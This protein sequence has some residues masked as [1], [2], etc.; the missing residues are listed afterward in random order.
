[1]TPIRLGTRA[2]RLALI[3]SD[4]VI[5]ALR[6]ADPAVEVEIV[7]ITSAG[8]RDRTTPLTSGEGAGWFTSALQ[9]ALREGAVDFL[10]HSYKDLPTAR[11]EGFVIAAV[12]PRADPRDALVTR[13]RVPLADL[14]SGST[15]GTSS[16]RREAQLRALRPD[17]AFRPI[18]G[19]VETRIKRVDDGE[20]D[21]TVLALA[22][23]DRLGLAPRADY[24]FSSAEMLPAPAQGALAVECRSADA[25]LVTLLGQIDDP[26]TRATVECERAFLG[27]LEAGCSFPA[28]AFAT[29]TVGALR[30]DAMAATDGRLERVSVDGGEPLGLG[31][32]AASLILGRPP[33]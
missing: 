1:M 27:A 30:L 6:E 17:L 20:F 12:P 25:A 18:R 33:G 21:A 22:G 10:V 14:A 4:I 8:D 5:A 32:T 3:Q 24:V 2:S 26:A 16:P 7:T 29:G 13:R 9:D 15:I 31:R 11:P 28:G 23:L 19:N